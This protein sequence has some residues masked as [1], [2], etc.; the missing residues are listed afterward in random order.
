M[1]GREVEEVMAR[2]LPAR[3]ARVAAIWVVWTAWALGR[4]AVA[5]A[6]QIKHP[7][8]F[9]FELPKIGAAW[10]Q[11]PRGD[12]IAVS[13]ESTTLPELQIFVFPA[14][15]E[16]SLAEIEGRLASELA[17][18]GVSLAGDPVK[19]IKLGQ[20]A[21]ETIADASARLGTATLNGEQA[22][23]A[24]VQRKG[25][26]LVLVGV[27]RPG[28]FER[29]AANFR[30]VVHGLQAARSATADRAPPTAIPPQATPRATPPAAARTDL[31]R[32]PRV[33]GIRDVTASST[34]ADRSRKDLYGAWRTVAFAQQFDEA[35]DLYV[36]VTAWCEGKPDEGV[37][38]TV[39]ITLA[40]ATRID[41]I[42]IAAGVWKSA[43]LFAANNQITALEVTLDGKTTRVVPAAAR[44]WLEVPIGRPVTTL[45]IKIAEVKKGKMNDSCL[46]GI[47][48]VQG[49]EAMSPLTGLDSAAAATDL[50]R[51]LAA[52]QAALTAPGRPGLDK[53]LE[54]PFVVHDASGF[55][56]GAPGPITHAGW[57]AVDAACRAAD[58]ASDRG[59]VD[60]S[61]P[62][63]CPRPADVDPSDTRP[64][65]LVS[66]G[67]GKI[68]ITFPS[69]REIS[70]VWRLRWRDSAWRLS[71]IDYQ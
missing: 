70:E 24:I 54:F 32:L 65:I 44:T 59:Q 3:I 56:S 31:P 38:E 64:A 16:G 71:A 18:P 62:V 5:H 50:P 30:A 8:G 61:R 34:F 41:A 43:K 69:H 57:K 40:A 2:S 19:T 1:R 47:E 11:E 42:K 55:F 45:A 53:L 58:K 49:G 12:L 26:S 13:D 22:V 51:A 67:P 10:E 27:P 25:K 23:F 52:L 29:G 33:I 21:G 6:D 37:G 66:D 4:G 60:E 48:L 17:R 39:T 35:A 46:S 36:P 68:E 7:A 15:K 20:A 9:T 63:S 14:K 28:I